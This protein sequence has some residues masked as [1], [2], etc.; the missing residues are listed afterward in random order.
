MVLQHAGAVAAASA[1]PVDNIAL[2]DRRIWARDLDRWELFRTLRE[3]RP[4]AFQREADLEGFPA[5]KGYWSIV[6]YDDVRAVSRDHDTFC[7]GQIGRAHV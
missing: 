3:Q 5:G 4:V 1:L 7:N 6:R 2:A